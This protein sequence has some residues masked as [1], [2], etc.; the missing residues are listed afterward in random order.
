MI[1]G[2]TFWP[3]VG[4]NALHMCSNFRPCKPEPIMTGSGLIWLN[5][6][7]DLEMQNGALV[8]C[9]VNRN[10]PMTL[11][12]EGWMTLHMGWS[13]TR[14]SF[15]TIIK[16]PTGKMAVCYRKG[17]I[18]YMPKEMLCQEEGNKIMPAS[19]LRQESLA[20]GGPKAMACAQ[21]VHRVG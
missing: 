14:G 20:E 18:S 1:D 11:L 10:L 12:S 8:G 2:G 7:A 15:G 4:K 13:T 5:E 6:M 19:A 21:G 16:D 17:V 9:L 3:I